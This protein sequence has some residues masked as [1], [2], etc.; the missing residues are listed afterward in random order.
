[1][2]PHIRT[3]FAPSPTGFLHVGGARTALY[4]WL[5]ARKHGG[6]FIYRVEDT[7]EARS[8]E[9]SLR[10]QITDM[11]WLA[12]NWNEGPDPQSLVDS[13]PYPPYR[14]SRRQ[15]IYKKYAEQL[16]NEGKA[17]YCFMTDEEI[18]K[19]REQLLAQGKP[20]QVQSPYRNMS[21]DEALAKIA[22]GE[23]AVVRFKTSEVREY[24]LQDLVRGEVRFP[25]DM[26]GDFVMLRSSGMPVYNFCCVIDDALMKISH[27]L[28]GEEHLSNTLRQMMLYD[29][30]GF[31][32]PQFGHLSMILGTDKQKLSKRHGATSVNQYNEAGFLPEAMLN[33]LALLGWSSPDGKEIMSV[34]EMIQN[35]SPDRLHASPAVF[36]ETKLLWMNAMHLRA[37]PHAELWRR[38]EPFLTAAGL[39]L[40]QD[41]EWQDRAL[42]LLK[43]SMQTLKDAV[44]LFRPLSQADLEMSAEG[45]DVL[46]TEPSAKVIETWKTKIQS[47]GGNY[48]SEEQFL[49]IQDEIKNELGVKGKNLFFPIRVAVIGKPHGAELKQLVPLISTS[50]LVERADFVLNQR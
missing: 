2:T 15:D 23:K 22:K 5:F 41:S 26:V 9:E 7:D 25:S 42:G 20:P 47:S 46:A 14:Q 3:R 16:L 44:E 19:Q 18:E 43:T 6:E 24:V 28:R 12:L 40:P 36:D 49:K 39:K 35:F 37:L 4:N 1:M 13:G 38:V 50:S 8:T 34:E 33:F 10:M 27:V 31:P 29:A 48:L 21:R 11:N 32:Q 30:F 45:K 17:Y